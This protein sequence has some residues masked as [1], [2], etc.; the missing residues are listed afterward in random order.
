MIDCIFGDPKLNSWEKEF[1]D[2]V[3]RQGWQRDYS[4]KQKVV[5]KRIYET[6]KKRYSVIVGT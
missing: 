5:I 4:P 2:S 1:I 6:Q 3:A